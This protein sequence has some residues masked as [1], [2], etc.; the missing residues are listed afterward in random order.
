VAEPQVREGLSRVRARLRE[1]G[2]LPFTDQ[3]VPSVV[4]LVA[5]APISGSWW[6]HPAG[7]LIYRVGEA[8]EED[9]DVVTVR[10]WCRK[11]TLVHRRLWPALVRVGG[12]RS[13][14]QTLGMSDSSARLLREIQR[15]TKARDDGRSV[16][17]QPGAMGYRQS[18]RDLEG[19]LLVLTRSVHT[20]TGAHAL[21][22]ESWAAW[23]ARNRVPRHTGTIVS[24]QL[25]LEEAAHLL[26]PEIDA[27]RSLPWGRVGRAAPRPSRA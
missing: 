13:T 27:R 24:A 5:G 20:D 17:P 16:E 3:R 10:L 22:A 15:D 7:A 25:V 8:L 6:G 18:L 21:E 19:R 2:L 14:W 26:A 12:S 23:A 4:S 9:S 11:I 1:T